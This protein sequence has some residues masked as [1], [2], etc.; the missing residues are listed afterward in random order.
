MSSSINTTEESEAISAGSLPGSTAASTSSSA[1]ASTPATGK[2]RSAVWDH[3]TKLPKDD[4][5]VVQQLFTH[6]C[7]R[8]EKRLKLP[9]KQSKGGGY[10]VSSKAL[11]HIR[12]NHKD[13]VCH[14]VQKSNELMDKKRDAL[15]AMLEHVKMEDKKKI[16]VN[17][18]RLIQ[19]SLPNTA[20]WD[21]VALSKQCHWFTYGQHSFGST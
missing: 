10:Y 8:C 3:F 1:T 7:L 4:E 6:Q 15:V 11:N 20:S 14:A 17:P 13:I 12:T 9:Y 16:K 2:T 18:E 19:S 21:D 5:D